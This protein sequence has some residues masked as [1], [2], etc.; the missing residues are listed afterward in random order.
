MKIIEI[1]PDVYKRLEELSG[2]YDNVEA[3]VEKSLKNYLSKKATDLTPL[4]WFC[5]V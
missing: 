4:A 1:T 5:G 2:N 3:F